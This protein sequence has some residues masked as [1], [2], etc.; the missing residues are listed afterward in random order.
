MGTLMHGNMDGVRDM[1]PT[2]TAEMRK[3]TIVNIL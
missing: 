2:P 3:V 1:E